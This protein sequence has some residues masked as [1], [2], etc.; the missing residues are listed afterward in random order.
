MTNEIAGAQFAMRWVVSTQRTH[1]VSALTILS[2]N[3]AEIQFASSFHFYT[4]L[5]VFCFS[6]E[7]K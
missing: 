2:S 1:I 6:I 7:N 4:F 5:K 3:I